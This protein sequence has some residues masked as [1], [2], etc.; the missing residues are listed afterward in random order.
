MKVSEIGKNFTFVS[1]VD[2]VGTLLAA[3]DKQSGAALHNCGKCKAFY[4]LETN[5]H[6]HHV[7]GVRSATPN[8]ND[9][10]HVHMEP[11]SRR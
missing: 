3:L 11:D 10:V 5:G 7:Y 4:V 1:A 9:L 6:Y 8:S 2:E